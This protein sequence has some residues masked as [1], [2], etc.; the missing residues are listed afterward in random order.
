MPGSARTG[1]VQLPRAWEDRRYLLWGL[2]ALTLAALL[3]AAALHRRPAVPRV[4]GTNATAVLAQ[5]AAPDAR[6]TADLARA[7]GGDRAAAVRLAYRLVEAG[8]EHADPRYHGRAQAVLARWWGEATPPNDV[9]LLRATIRQA[10][11]D[12][13]AARADLDL[14]V[15]RDPGDPNARLTRAAVAAVMG[16]L[17]TTKTDC[18]ALGDGAAVLVLAC[19]SP[20]QRAGGHAGAA[21]RDLA[22]ALGERGTGDASVDVWAWTSL[23]EL[24]RQDGVDREA[25]AAFRRALALDPT[26]SYALVQLADL[27]LAS[28]RDAEVVELLR[29][30]GEADGPLLRLAIAEHRL[31]DPAGRVHAAL[32]LS[33]LV[34]G[35]ERG[36]DTH[37][38]EYALYL[39]AIAGDGPGALRAALRNWELQK[40]SIDGQLVLRAAAAA[41]D[42]A[43]AAGVLAWM[44]EHAVGDAMLARARAELEAAR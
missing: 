20:I 26:D 18:E 23:G 4:S 30:A 28:G 38:R 2:G 8:R 15:S 44:T 3:V 41:G 29:G 22:A 39:L 21:Y 14:L 25:E 31:R 13:A 10:V 24:A 27:L 9:L 37:Q 43:A 35:M 17:A 1:A 16:D 11:H 34:A 42:R 5:V 40:E 36:D 33:R 7:L 6:D 19:L 32:S 12:F